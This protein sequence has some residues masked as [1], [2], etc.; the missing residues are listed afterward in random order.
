MLT[1]L[2]MS[3]W[4]LS[5]LLLVLLVLFVQLAS[6]PHHSDMSNSV[7][8]ALLEVAP[9]ERYL[10]TNVVIPSGHTMGELWI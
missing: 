3:S 4:V 7:V 8:E 5:K 2:M 6:V 1:V 9:A 10:R